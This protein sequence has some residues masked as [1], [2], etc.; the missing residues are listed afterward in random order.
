M[1]S[2]SDVPGTIQTGV[3][4]ARADHL[5]GTQAAT[6]DDG[7]ELAGRGLVLR[8][9]LD[10]EKG[11]GHVTSFYSATGSAATVGAPKSRPGTSGCGPRFR[12][13]AVD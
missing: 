9:E 3:L 10:D 7:L 8:P 4:H 2:V 6:S 13:S 1:N 5:I 12:R 11:L